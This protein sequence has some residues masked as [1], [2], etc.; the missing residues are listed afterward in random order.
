M[1]KLILGRGGKIFTWIFLTYFANF[2]T[3]E[4]I[5]LEQ[6]DEWEELTKFLQLQN[7]N[8]VLLG[9]LYLE[10]VEQYPKMTLVLNK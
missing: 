10:Y 7:L 3:P 9:K 1:L 2:D 4:W 6:V 8:N 5:L